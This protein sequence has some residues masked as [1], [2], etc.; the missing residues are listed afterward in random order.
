MLTQENIRQ[1]GLNQQLDAQLVPPARTYVH[2]TSDTG[3]IFP[4][5]QQRVAWTQRLVRGLIL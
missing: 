3:D 5:E 2:L 4:L 1:K